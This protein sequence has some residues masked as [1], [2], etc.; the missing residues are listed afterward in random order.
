MLSSRDKESAYASNWTFENAGD[1]RKKWPNC[2]KNSN[3]ISPVNIDLSKLNPCA[4]LCNLAVK[5]QGF[6]RTYVSYKNQMPTL[7]FDPGCV[8]KFQR[9][10]YFLKKMTIHVPSLHSVNGERMDMEILLYHQRNRIS[11]EDGGV[12]I[13]IMCKKGY[14]YGDA[15]EFLNEIINQIPVKETPVEEEIPTSSDW[16]PEKLFP[17]NKSFFYYN[18][19]LPYPPCSQNWTYIIFEE[20]VPISQNIIE[21]IKYAIGEPNKNVRPIQP[22]PDSVKIMYNNQADFDT[23]KFDDTETKP[24]IRE[25]TQELMILEKEKNKL[26]GTLNR[27]LIY[28]KG[29]VIG[30]V[31]FMFI[32]LAIKIAKYIVHNDILNNFLLAQVG[33]KQIRNANKAMAE[34]GMSPDM[35]GSPGMSP[36]MMGSPGMTPDMMGTPGMTPDMMGAPGMTPVGGLPPGMANVGGLPPGM[37]NVGGLPPGVGG[38]PPGMGN[39]GGLPPSMG[40]VGGLPPGQGGLPPGLVR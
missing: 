4:T 26:K 25:V 11:F 27:N 38:L 30:I 33:K 12:I 37:A 15:N 18:G 34:G 39:V 20:V 2:S 1:W 6:D 28:F 21:T 29:L 32:Y 7:T 40:N 3:R 14:D 24:Q 22:L 23:Y 36:D 19:G 17:E 16:N 10:F 35:M 13:S 9:N 5:Y 8:I 31:F